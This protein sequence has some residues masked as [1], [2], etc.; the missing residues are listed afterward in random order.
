MIKEINGIKLK[1]AEN[2]AE[3]ALLGF[4][5]Q[6]AIAVEYGQITLEISVQ[7]GKI[8]H[9]NSYQQKKTFNFRDVK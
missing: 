9:L 7:N 2:N 3:R 8:T 5:S 6:E 1:D 4:L